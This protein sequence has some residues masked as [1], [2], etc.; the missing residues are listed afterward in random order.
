M[1]QTAFST[2]ASNRI[3]SQPA[4]PTKIYARS[5]SG[6]DAGSLALYGDVSATPAT[7]SITLNGLVEVSSTSIFDDLTQAI[8]SAAQTGVVTA[9]GAG[10]AATGDIAFLINPSDAA[11]L[12]LG[13]KVYRFKNTLAAINDV[14]IGATATDTALSLKRAINLDGTAGV[15]YFAGTTA[16]AIYSATVATTIVTITDR[17]ACLRQVAQTITES[18]SNFAIR[19]PIGGADGALLFTLAVGAT[20]SQIPLTFST[21]DHTTATL[22]ARMLATSNA[23]NTQG[24]KCMLRLWSNQGISYKVQSSTDQINWNNTSEGTVALSASTLTNVTL[25]E[26]HEFIRF[27]ITT[28]SNTTDSIADFRVIY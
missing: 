5:T 18:G 20:S 21:E 2:T 17:I 11:T 14:K 6:G 10:T 23:I 26:L 28:N 27:V 8:L 16:N 24:N 25:A 13:G 7:Q 19:L 4:S 15:D 12:T 3:T 9:Y 1:S 22:P